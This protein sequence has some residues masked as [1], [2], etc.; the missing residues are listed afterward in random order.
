M[1]EH[2][3]QLRP[4]LVVCLLLGVISCENS[5]S[6]GGGGG[7]DWTPAGTLAVSARAVGVPYM[8]ASS[9]TYRFTIVGGAYSVVNPP[10]SWNTELFYYRNRPVAWESS[11]DDG[12][13]HPVG[14]DGAVGVWSAST[15][16]AAAAGRGAGQSVTVNLAA[17]EFVAFVAPDCL[18]CFGNNRGS[19]TLQ[20]EVS[21]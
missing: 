8:A 11:S 12:F 15:T 10:V 5:G 21:D 13:Q 4:F 9:G 6:G 1:V 2:L 3:R 18:D 14:E 19:V 20:V 7:G 17:G 16:A